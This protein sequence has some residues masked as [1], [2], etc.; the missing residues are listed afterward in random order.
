MSRRRRRIAT[1]TFVLYLATLS[2]DAIRKVTGLPA[3]ILGVI[4]L[5]TAI[6]YISVIPGTAGQKHEAPRVVPIWLFLLSLWC[7]VVALAQQIP[8]EVA[9]IGWASYVFF[10]PLLYVGAELAADDRV[11]AKA[12]K[13]IVISGGIVGIGAIVSAL[14]GQ[15][16]PALLQPII[17]TVGIHS[18]NF[19]N[20]YLSPSIFADAEEASEQLLI[21]LFAWAAL[22]HLANGG[23]P[24]IPSAFLG[25][26]IASGLVIVARRADIY[27]AIVGLVAVLF[28]GRIRASASAGTLSARI[29]TQTRGR[30]GTAAFLAAAGSVGIIFLGGTKLVSFLTS[31]GSVGS[32]ILF[33]FSLTSSGSLIG[34]GPGTSTQG[35]SVVGASPLSTTGLSYVLGGR[36]FIIAEGALGKTWLE[37]GIMGL[38]L[39]G[40]VFWAALAPAIRSWRRLDKVGVAFTMLAIALGV[41][42]LKGHQSLD[43][44]LIQP[45]FW[46]CV[47]GIWGR[48]RPVAGVLRAE[49]G[50]GVAIAPHLPRLGLSFRSADLLRSRTVLPSPDLSSGLWLALSVGWPRLWLRL[51]SGYD[52]SLVGGPVTGFQRLGVVLSG[53]QGW[54]RAGQ[55][56]RGSAFMRSRAGDRVGPWPGGLGFSAKQAES[57]G[58]RGDDTTPD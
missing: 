36:T 48:M 45:L 10:V 46:L 53:S 35:V 25:V 47:G 28:L 34:Q 11:A 1:L 32:R 19:G 24:R 31:G 38:I 29:T 49:S 51:A 12:L 22:A 40:V 6:I 20:I 3:S 14:L 37:L 9:L 56:A 23:L 15:S 2:L 39:Y 17:P 26:L 8:L 18:S 33:M 43:D 41:V 57:A 52:G 7:L 50:I 16:A 44:P 13:V 4:Y 27:V 58:H 54:L 42:F 5:I 21:A 30:L 55:G